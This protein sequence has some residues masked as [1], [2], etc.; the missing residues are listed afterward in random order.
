MSASFT[1]DIVRDCALLEKEKTF[2]NL[3][4]LICAH[5]DVKAAVWL[6]GDEEKSLTFNQLKQQADNW[7]V[8]LAKVFGTEGRVCISLD[9]CKEWFPLFWGLVRSGHDIL[10]LDASLPD[11]KAEKLMAECNC[12]AIVSGKRHK[13]S[14]D[15]KQAL[16]SDFINSPN[17]DGYT[18]IWGHDIALC[19]S[20]TTS[21]SRIFVYNEE[22]ICYLAL[23]S[24]KVHDEN[25][26]LIDDCCFRTLAFLPFH[27]VLGF[28]AI[29]IWSHFLGDTMVYLK[30]R[31][32][33]T[34][35]RTMQKCKANQIVA[36]PI[37]ANSIYRSVMAK[38]NN[39]GVLE[40]NI[41][42]GMVSTS[43]AIQ[44]FAPKTG[45][46]IAKSMFRKIQ[47]QIF[48]T[49][50]KS[51]VLGGSHTDP[52]SLRFLNAIGYYTICGF[53]MTETA[54]NG[55]ETSYRL[56]NRLLGSIGAP[57]DYTEYK[58]QET[59]RKNKKETEPK[60]P[61][62]TGELLIRGKGLHDGRFV[63]G[64]LLPPDIDKDGWFHTGDI[65]RIIEA[66]GQYFIEGRIKEVIVNESGENVYPDEME[67]A[68]SGIK[69]QYTILGL[70]RPHSK[71]EDIT[72]AVGIGEKIGD[73]S[74][75]QNL[76][77][78][79]RLVNKTLP[80]YKRLARAIVTG[81]SMPMTTTMK[82]KRIRL[83]E[84]IESG[85][86]KFRN[87]DLSSKA[88]DTEIRPSESDST[89]PAASAGAP[90]DEKIL[91]LVKGIY[92]QVLNLPADSI[93]PDA[94]FIDDL[95]GD[96]LE[97]L[98][99]ITRAEDTFSVMIPTE[100]Y[101]VCAT[102][103]GAVDILTKLINHDSVEGGKQELVERTAVTRFEDSAEYKH[104]EDRVDELMKDG[105]NPYFVCHESPL[106]DTSVIDGKE[107]LD[108]GSYNYVGM[109]GRKEVNDAAK[110]A[111]DKYGTSASGSRLL[112]GQKK[113]HEEL[114]KEIAEWKHSESALVCVGGHSTN[115]TVVGNF[116][117]KND[118]ILYD[119]LAHNSVEQGCKLSDATAKP[120]PHNDLAAL[121]RILIAQRKY[122]EKV[123]IVIEGAYSMDGDISDVPGFVA[124][125]KKYG[126]FLMV[127]EAHSACVLG[128][129]G[130]GVDEYFGLAPDDIDI[131][132]GTLSKG[133]GTCG[134]Y[135]AGRKCLIEYL[136]YNLPGFVFSVGMSPALAAGSLEAV[137]L[138]RANPE[139]MESLHSNIKFFAEEA[140][141]RKL[142]IGRAGETA[143]LPVLIGP[144]ENAVALSN[145]LLKRGVSV[146]PA[147]YPAVPK[148]KA[149]LRFDVC[150]EHKK[151]QIVYAL[152]T[153]IQ[154]AKDL[155]ID[156]PLKE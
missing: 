109:S 81:E 112:A 18:P 106:R 86:L 35:T 125:K 33:L 55:F 144:D 53:G 52:E 80:G 43:L 147:L 38:I 95:G 122:F 107:V 70:K 58:I 67:D 156:L 54:I 60:K 114:E 115:V 129:T 22:T 10:T 4:E 12:K 50:M 141:K 24:R 153:L 84:M 51:I 30:D 27:H 123:L 148:N 130:G 140:G 25:R 75:I 127:D 99:I 149:R 91:Y 3:Y 1:Y 105:N 56:D 103:N 138:L 83:K 21:D 73:E 9:S 26:L 47:K 13:F 108:F 146:P 57:M 7:A 5:G 65:I 28:A 23:F 34:I 8:A 14:P 78:E 155:G 79:I 16:V 45:L 76:S 145:E 94:N 59:G 139:I 19:T 15:I 126:C 82:V 97:V 36:V 92:A 136:R 77:R 113:V 40:R 89:A 69:D 2:R 100:C 124:L 63:D 39:Q 87:L 143:I 72:L 31:S 61:G 154:A 102:I 85:E 121:E 104:F 41:F 37:L 11:D 42:K 135:L 116:C 98:D 20:G 48:G 132:M 133:L 142:D 32:P 119:A 17:V 6:E 96:S 117:G 137:R 134:G 64:K 66:P 152:D 93:D 29:F 120:F 111:I 110:A 90:K 88:E 71:Y 44:T 49:N 151:E 131:K 62:K 101:P 74:Y 150:S 128:K 68:F 46:R 118:L